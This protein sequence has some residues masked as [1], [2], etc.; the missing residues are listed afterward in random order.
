[1]YGLTVHVR[2]HYQSTGV[3]WSM[4]NAQ[5]PDLKEKDSFSFQAHKVRRDQMSQTVLMTIVILMLLAFIL[6]LVIGVILTR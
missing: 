3:T 5:E 4:V 2:R 1:M 6:G